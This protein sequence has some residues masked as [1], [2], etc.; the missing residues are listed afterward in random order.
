M[1]NGLRRLRYFRVLANELNFRR[2]A[3]K[4]GMTQPALSRAIALLENDVGTPLLERTNRQVRLTL[5]GEAFASGSSRVL[6]AL[7]LAIDQTLKVASGFTGTLVI[8]YTDTAIAGRLPDIIQSFRTARPD[9]H[10]RLVQSYTHRQ[11]EMLDEGALDIG[12]LTGPVSGTLYS[13]IDTQRDPLFAVLPQD[14]PLA[15]NDSVLLSDLADLPFVLGDLDHWGAFHAHL[16]AHCKKAGFSPNIVQTAP[17]SRALFGLVSCGTGVSVQAKSLILRGDARIVCKPLGDKVEP[18]V[19][20]AVWSRRNSPP[21]LAQL[22][23]HV[24]GYEAM[25]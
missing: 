4:L 15:D 25:S 5:A 18:V 13:A 11:L 17:D 19:T 24:A 12:F 23:E 10:L 14:H 8:G 2:A 20:Q 16:F 9:I 1:E 21:A 7:D 3:A 22:I 6:A